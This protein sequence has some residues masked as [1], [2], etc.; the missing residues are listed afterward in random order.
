VDGGAF[1]DGE[2]D[3]AVDGAADGV[4]VLG[5]DGAGGVE[6][7]DDRALHDFGDIDGG[8]EIVIGER[9][10][11]SEECCDEDG[12]GKPLHFVFLIFGSESLLRNWLI[13]CLLSR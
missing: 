4:F 2:V 9:A 12:G 11:A 8:T 5:G 13:V 3:D 1:V 7:L 6:G 10:R